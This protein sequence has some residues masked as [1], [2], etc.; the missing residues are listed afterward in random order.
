M[1]KANACVS[2]CSFH[3]CA[4]GSQQSSLLCVFHHEEC[5]AVF[6]GASWILKLG[7]SKDIAAGLFREALELDEGCIADGC[8]G[9]LAC[10]AQDRCLVLTA[11]ESIYGA[12]SLRHLDAILVDLLCYRR[13]IADCCLPC[14]LRGEAA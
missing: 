8:G 11:C 9:G 3:H 7:L 6:D 10:V 12:L 13:G 14:G 5:C 4:A 1:R 2:C